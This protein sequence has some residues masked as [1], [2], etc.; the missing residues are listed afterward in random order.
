MSTFGSRLNCLVLDST[1]DSLCS[2]QVSTEEFCRNLRE[3]NFE[4]RM[5]P[6]DF[7]ALFFMKLREWGSVADPRAA[8]GGREP[9][10]AALACLAAL[11]GVSSLN[12]RI[13]Y[14]D[15]VQDLRDAGGSY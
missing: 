5:S 2:A 1:L 8:D 10:A 4:M 11:K 12:A 14:R 13:E 7:E 3:L 15:R 9:A 6:D